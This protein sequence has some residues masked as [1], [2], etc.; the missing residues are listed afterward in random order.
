L[1]KARAR[2]LA[3]AFVARESFRPGPAALTLLPEPPPSPRTLSAFGL[4]AAG[5]FAASVELLETLSERRAR[6]GGRLSETDMAEL[7]VTAEDLRILAAALKTTRAQQPDREPGGP[8]PP[9]DSPF[10]AL[11]AL[12]A[13]PEPPRRRRP[14]KRSVQ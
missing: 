12:T 13:A 8:R 9:K 10:A 2:T 4:R 5:W 3:Q 6:G 7:G 14:R 11:S 1:L